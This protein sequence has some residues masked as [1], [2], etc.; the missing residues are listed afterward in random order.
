[1]RTLPHVAR[2]I[3]NADTSSMA[4]SLPYLQCPATTVPHISFNVVINNITG[5]EQK[6]TILVGPPIFTTSIGLG[7]GAISLCQRAAAT[8][9][10]V[11]SAW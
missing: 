6:V 3:F 8:R 10:I 7:S 5:K 1:M 2:T 11:G 9:S 4:R